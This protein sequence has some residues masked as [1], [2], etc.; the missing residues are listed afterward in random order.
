MEIKSG[1]VRQRQERKRWVARETN[2][3]RSRKLPQCAGQFALTSRGRGG[4]TY[5]LVGFIFATRP[6]NGL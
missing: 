4:R 3:R 5:R 1:A 6:A 2:G